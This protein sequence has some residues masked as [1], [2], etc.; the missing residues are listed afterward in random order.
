MIAISPLSTCWEIFWRAPARKRGSAYLFPA[1]SRTLSRTGI[2]AKS[3]RDVPEDRKA[4]TARSG[5]RQGA[6]RSL[7][8]Q[9][10]I[11]GCSHAVSRSCRCPH[12]GR[13]NKETLEV[14]HKIAD[15]DPQNTDIRL[16]LAEGY[17]KEGMQAEAAKAFTQAANRLLE[18]RAV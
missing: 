17:L 7:S 16:K 5:D 11:A 10:L 2:P 4:Q 13:R 12:P 9:G 8:A 3:H 14:L 15:L 6:W 1:D 18:N